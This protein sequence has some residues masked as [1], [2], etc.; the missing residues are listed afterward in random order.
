MRI[1]VDPH[2]STSLPKGRIDFQNVHAT[3]EQGIDLHQKI[4]DAAVIMEL[5]PSS[6]LSSE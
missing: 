4:D 5:K 1:H 2:D 3:S 6:G